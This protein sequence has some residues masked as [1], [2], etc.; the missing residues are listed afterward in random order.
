MKRWNIFAAE[1]EDIL[2]S[3]GVSLSL[4]D[5]RASVHREK[6]RRLSQSLLK[7][8]SFPILTGSEPF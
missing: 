6:V 1:L 5:V 4:L 8:K 3:R 7:P 2:A